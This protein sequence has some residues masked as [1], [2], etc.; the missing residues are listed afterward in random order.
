MGQAWQDF[1]ALFGSK[2]P[3]G[4]PGFLVLMSGFCA[5]LA[6][7]LGTEAGYGGADLAAFVCCIAML[8]LA[9]WLG[10]GALVFSADARSLCLPGSHRH[11]RRAILIASVLLVAIAVIPGAALGRNPMWQ[12]WMPTG[13]VL[14][15]ALAGVSIPFLSTGIVGLLLLVALTGYWALRGEADRY[16]NIELLFALLS[17]ALA[18]APVAKWRR[19]AREGRRTPSLL[20]LLQPSWAPTDH[21]PIAT[22]REPGKP[23]TAG[24]LRVTAGALGDRPSSAT[25]IRTCLGGYFARQPGRKAILGAVVLVALMAVAGSLPPGGGGQWRWAITL[26]AVLA[27]SLIWGG[28][29]QYISKLTRG[30]IAELALLPGL[31]A[32]IARRRALYWAVLAPP[33]PWLV[34]MLLLLGSAGLLLKRVPLSSVGALGVYLAIVWLTYATLALVKLTNFPPRHRSRFPNRF[35]AIAE[36][37]WLYFGVYLCAVYESLYVA[38]FSAASPFAH[39]GFVIWAFWTLPVLVGIWLASAIGYALRR[40][41]S[42]PH[43]FLW[44]ACSVITEARYTEAARIMRS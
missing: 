19:V 16:R 10:A 41:A 21:R 2:G 40:L 37:L 32:G 5:A 33:I 13:V 28:F 42:A 26:E 43:P 12:A 6:Y 25:A 20:G 3:V 23:A 14:G 34:G 22:T 38:F 15:I 31:G 27:A 35:P 36:F 18:L 11:K 9:Y 4:D 30:D 7:P 17:A 29:L 24:A 1:A 8:F 44:R 39:V